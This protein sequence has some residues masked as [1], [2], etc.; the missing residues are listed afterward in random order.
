MD[1]ILRARDGRMVLID[2]DAGGVAADLR[3]ID[4]KLK[5]RFA[6]NGNP[7]FWAVYEESEDGRT[8]HLVTTVQAHQTR[9]GT[10]AG[11]DQRVVERI[12]QIGHSSYD[13]AA[14]VERQNREASQAAKRRFEEQTGPLAEQAAFAI[15]KDLGMRYKGRA[16]KP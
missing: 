7:P 3:A 11:L 9:S 8:T 15:R 16:F 4:P 2:A 10:W 6:E 1:Q 5:V 12:R 13:Y 14:E